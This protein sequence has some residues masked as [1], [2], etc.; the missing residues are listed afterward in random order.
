MRDGVWY[1]VDLHLDNK[2]NFSYWIWEN[3]KLVTSQLVHDAINPEGEIINE[4]LTGFAFGLVFARNY[5]E[6]WSLEFDEIKIQ[7]L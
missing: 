4:K 1:N 3:K 6:G 7:W 5:N 2:S